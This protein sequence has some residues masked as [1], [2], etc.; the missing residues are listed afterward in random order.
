MKRII[1]EK[2]VLDSFALLS[3]LKDENSSEKVVE[4]INLAYSGTCHLAMSLLNL[5]EVFY[6]M[7]R[8]KSEEFAIRQEAE[9][10]RLPIEFVET[11]WELIREAAMIKARYPIAFADCFA[12]ALAFRINAS[13]MTGDPEF[14]Q[15]KDK[16]NILWL[17]G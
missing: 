9:I 8:E 3:L 4:K 10:F 14:R 5:G 11:D 1:K 7:C 2:I 12:A 6:I 16:L 17:Q 15:I 13:L